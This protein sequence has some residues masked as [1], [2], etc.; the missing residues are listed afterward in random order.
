MVLITVYSL[1]EN[2]RHKGPA[3][4]SSQ[5]D[6]VDMKTRGIAILREK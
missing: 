4:F 3:D 6:M 2:R 1:I 5:L